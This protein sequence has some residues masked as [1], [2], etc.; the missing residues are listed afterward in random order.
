MYTGFRIGEICA[1]I[2]PKTDPTII[3][4]TNSSAR[5]EG[6][7]YED[8]L[9][10]SGKTKC[11]GITPNI[12]KTLNSIPKKGLYIMTDEKGRQLTPPQFYRH[13]RRCFS[14]TGLPYLSLHKCRHTY[15]ISD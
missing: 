11:S 10:K 2:W 8:K 4:I 3:K 6:E 9:P 1:L 5:K 13:Y 14:E 12:Q 15:H 7:G